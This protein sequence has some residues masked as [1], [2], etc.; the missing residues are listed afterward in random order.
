V[1]T[2]K[3][4]DQ[5]REDGV[6]TTLTVHRIDPP[7]SAGRAQ[8]HGPMVS[9]WTRPGGYSASFDNETAHRFELV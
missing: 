9:A 1:W 2:L 3:V 4:G 8:R 7:M 6:E 5:V